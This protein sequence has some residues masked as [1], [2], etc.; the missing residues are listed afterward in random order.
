MVKVIAIAGTIEYQHRILAR[1]HS[2]REPAAAAVIDFVR[3]AESDR[4]QI[5]VRVRIETPGNSPPER[6]SSWGL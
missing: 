6:F 4:V 5:D 2:S 3:L 1:L